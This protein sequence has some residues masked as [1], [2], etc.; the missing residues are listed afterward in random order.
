MKFEKNKKDLRVI[1]SRIAIKKSFLELLR[2]NSIERITIN[3]ICE[4]AEI[5]RMTFYNHYEDKYDLFIDC[6]NDIKKEISETYKIHTQDIEIKA[7]P[8]KC[9]MIAIRLILDKCDEYKD[10]LL[11]IATNEENSM[12]LYIIRNLVEK[13]FLNL[14]NKEQIK[15]LIKYPIPIFSSFITWGISGAMFYWLTHQEEYTKKEFLDVIE[16]ILFNDIS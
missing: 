11:S 3:K 4:L 10:I 8:T 1:K 16:K 13:D 12:V 2:H 6:L 5:N 7:N 14:L 9:I 15:P